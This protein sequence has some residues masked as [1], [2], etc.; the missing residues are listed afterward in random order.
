LDTREVSREQ[1]DKWNVVR[2]DL[3]DVL[4]EAAEG[5]SEIVYFG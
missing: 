4:T 2:R 1:L 3:A 5:R